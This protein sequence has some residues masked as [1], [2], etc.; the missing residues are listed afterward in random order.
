MNRRNSQVWA[1]RAP[2]TNLPSLRGCAA[3][4][5]SH[6]SRSG[7][8]WSR[9]CRPR[10][11]SSCSGRAGSCSGT[12]GWRAPT[13][14][15]LCQC[16]LEGGEMKPLVREIRHWRRRLMI[17]R[18]KGSRAT[19]TVAEHRFVDSKRDGRHDSV[20]VLGRRLIK[21]TNARRA[22]AESEPCSGKRRR[23]RA[24]WLASS[25]ST[26]DTFFNISKR[27]VGVFIRQKRSLF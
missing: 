20:I 18:V 10:R 4:S 27:Y 8:T 23:K 26:R 25:L 2:K 24:I 17:Q 1:W 19:Q 13:C 21:V 3:R 11:C 9:G 14:V 22:S 16:I 5:S 7:S 12:L 6:T 15:H